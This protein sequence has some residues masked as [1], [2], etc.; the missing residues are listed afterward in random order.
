MSNAVSVTTT[1]LSDY[2]FL[3]DFGA[4]IPHLQA[5]EPAPLGAGEGP[6]PNQL[7]LAAVTNCLSSSLF[8]ALR[9]FKQDAGSITT[10][11]T[12]RIDRDED[13]RVRVQE[14]A[15]VIRLDRRPDEI[16]HLDRVLSQFEAFCT[17]TQSVRQGIPVAIAVE[18][19]QGIRVK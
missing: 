17:V 10:T 4:G 8:F 14:I 16:E 13:K 9:K 12:A 1:Q 3:V 19:K 2:R 6:S 15:V 11:A 5:D 7:L 18:D